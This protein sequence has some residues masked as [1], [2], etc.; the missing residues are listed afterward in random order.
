MTF[1][2]QPITVAPKN[3]GTEQFSPKRLLKNKELK[4]IFF[5]QNDNFILTTF[6]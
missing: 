2:S 3:G 4:N 6:F 5:E 1:S